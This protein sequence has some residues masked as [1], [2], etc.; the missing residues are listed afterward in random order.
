MSF[1]DR[2]PEIGPEGRICRACKIWKPWDEFHKKGNGLFGRH[3]QCGVCSIKKMAQRR[4]KKKS[5]SPNVID[6][7]ACQWTE[8]YA[9]DKDM[10][11]EFEKL[12]SNLI[13]DTIFEIDEGKK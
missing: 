9:L 2:T 13:Y 4:K 5:F 3:S 8:L 7:Q 6:L 12:I 11:A 1:N 10:K